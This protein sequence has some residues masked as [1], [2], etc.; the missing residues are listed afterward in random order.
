VT[1]I[2]FTDLYVTNLKAHCTTIEYI[3][4]NNRFFGKI[5]AE[6]EN[7]SYY[8]FSI[9]LQ[10]IFSFYSDLYIHISRYLLQQNDKCAVSH[11]H[12]SGIL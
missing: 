11:T 4:K 6:L 2:N 3:G 1:K 9:I 7:Y 8:L 12:T 5:T 10:Y